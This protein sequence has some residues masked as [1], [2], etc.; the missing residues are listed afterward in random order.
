MDLLPVD[1]QGALGV[2]V[3]PGHDLDQGG[4]A[5][6]V[7]TQHAGHLT[8]ADGQVDPGQRP[9]RAVGLADVVHL[10]QRLTLVQGRVR[11][12]AQSVRHLPHAFRVVASF[13][14]YRFTATAS[15]NMTP[16]KALNQFGSQPA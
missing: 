13:L 4:L 14:T 7:V 3:Q 16:R 2:P 15:S 12:F 10:D 11:V 9:D 6:T 1:L 5:G 8:G